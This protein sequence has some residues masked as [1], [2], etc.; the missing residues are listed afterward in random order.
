MV[1]ALGIL[2]GFLGGCVFMA[3]FAQ[4]IASSLAEELHHLGNK[5]Q[6]H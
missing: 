4:R 6:R 2:G 3:L 1:L 5:L